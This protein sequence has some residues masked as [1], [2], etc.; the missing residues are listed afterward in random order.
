MSKSLTHN[1]APRTNLE[2]VTRFLTKSDIVLNTEQ[3]DLLQRLTFTDDKIRS[4]KYTRDEIISL[5]RNRFKIS[6][7]RA[8]QDI[9]DTHRLF[10]Q[11]RKISKT[12]VLA[13]HIEEIERQIQLVKEARRFELLPK[14][15]DALTYA[16]NSLPAEDK[17]HEQPP[18]KIVFISNA[19][20]QEDKKTVTDILTEVDALLND[21]PTPD[22]DEYLEFEEEPE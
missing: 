4:R 20:R 2:A 15:N 10:G 6:E 9:T 18:F 13:Q 1:S 5:I 7:W 21:T 8:E 11:T 3:E 12:Y 17:E 16:L 19:T 22:N 14:L